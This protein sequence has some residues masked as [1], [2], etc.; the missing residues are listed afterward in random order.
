MRISKL[1]AM[2]GTAAVVGLASVA[3]LTGPV[4]AETVIH[5][6]NGA[7]PESLDPHKLTGVPEANILYDIGEGLLVAMGQRAAMSLWGHTSP[8]EYAMANT[9]PQSSIRGRKEL[10]HAVLA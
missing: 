10:T 7:E 6:G 4:A 8:E 1:M 2:L 9:D 5:R 3:S